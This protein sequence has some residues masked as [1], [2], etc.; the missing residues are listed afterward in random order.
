MNAE[1]PENQSKRM[2]GRNVVNKGAT[3]PCCSDQPDKTMKLCKNKIL[4]MAIL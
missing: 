1:V 3:M 4:I 2:N